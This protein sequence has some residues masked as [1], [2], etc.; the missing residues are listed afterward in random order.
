VPVVSEIA[1]KPRALVVEDEPDLRDL[2]VFHL[3]REGFETLGVGNGY[4]AIEVAQASTPDVI[5][6]DLMIEGLSGW[7]VCQNLRQGLNRSRASIMI[8]SA[9]A[10]EA[11]IVR[12]LEAGADDF[13][14]KP[15]QPREVMARVRA[16]LRRARADRNAAG[17]G[18]TLVVGSLA[19]DRDRF[20]ARIDG[21]VLPLT[22]TEY[23]I[24]VCFAENV[25]R[26]F[27]RTQLMEAATDQQAGA[28]G[29]NIDV[30]VRALRVKLGEHAS[31]VETI[32][33]VGY[34]I[35]A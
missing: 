18:S 17:A 11:D 28:R 14:C 32:R 34:R 13:V 25:G 10:E 2:L 22:T 16:L 3:R 23:R 5:L 27:T 30:H 12:G 24:L 9:L 21:R 4:E 31:L 35:S 33:G 19:I 29:R 15:F 1:R 8:V 26:V 20:E 7:K 6:L